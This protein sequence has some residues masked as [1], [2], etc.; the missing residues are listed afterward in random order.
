MRSIL[1]TLSMVM[2][3]FVSVAQF[4]KCS[5]YFSAH[6][7]D[8]QLFIGTNA[9]NDMQESNTKVVFIYVTAGDAGL[10]TGKVPPATVPY[11]VARERGAKY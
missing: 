9:Y 10:L 4:T 6:P 2:N 11:Y 5:F 8:W 7:D 3:G 1:I